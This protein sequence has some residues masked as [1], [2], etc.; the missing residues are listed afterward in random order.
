MKYLTA[1]IFPLLIVFG[2]AANLKPVD[3]EFQADFFGITTGVYWL[4]LTILWVLWRKEKRS[5]ESV[6]DKWLQEVDADNSNG[7]VDKAYAAKAGDLHV[8]SSLFG[9]RWLFLISPLPYAMIVT[10]IGI[11]ISIGV[12]LGVVFAMWFVTK[13][14]EGFFGG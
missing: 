7:L 6:K 14:A 8:E 1:A 2:L 3:Y 13:M 4:A 11:G 5:L 9:Y 12:Y 10:G